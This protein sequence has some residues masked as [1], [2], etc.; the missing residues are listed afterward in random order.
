ML[1]QG[2]C[3]GCAAYELRSGSFVFRSGHLTSGILTV[4]EV[5]LKVEE[6]KVYSQT[7]FLIEI[8]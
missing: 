3:V 5:E 6:D 1:D 7:L 4:Q 2:T 8:H